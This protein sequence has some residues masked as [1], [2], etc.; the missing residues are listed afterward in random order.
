[1]LY[2]YT[3]E[4]G[5]CCQYYACMGLL[6]KFGLS[7]LL[8]HNKCRWIKFL[9]DKLVIVSNS[10]FPIC[11]TEPRLKPY[12]TSILTTLTPWERQWYCYSIGLYFCSCTLLENYQTFSHI[13]DLAVA[14]SSSRI[15]WIWIGTP[16]YFRDFSSISCSGSFGE[17]LCSLK[18]C[19][20][21]VKSC[22]VYKC[23]L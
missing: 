1:M 6:S 9:W 3:C 2:I 11:K 7:Q 12:L 15:M 10:N 22:L 19:L 17:C 16:E 18:H 21:F 5:I 14:W 20:F 8:K 4:G 13:W 23:N